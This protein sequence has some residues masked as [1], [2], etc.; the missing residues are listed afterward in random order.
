MENKVGST[1][2]SRV[3]PSWADT[4]KRKAPSFFSQ[5]WQFEVFFH[6]IYHINMKR[7]PYPVYAGWYIYKKDAMT[8]YG[9]LNNWAGSLRLICHNSLIKN[10]MILNNEWKHVCLGLHFPHLH[11]ILWIF[12]RVHSLHEFIM[13]ISES[14][15]PKANLRLYFY[16]YTVFKRNRNNRI[17]HKG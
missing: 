17:C 15:E 4:T 1:K 8:K 9:P 2:T 7:R 12:L 13:L 11:F 5:L 10:V 6:I 3:Q 16:C 14:G